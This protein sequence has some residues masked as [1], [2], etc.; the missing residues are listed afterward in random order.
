MASFIHSLTQWRPIRRTAREGFKY[1]GGAF[2]TTVCAGQLAAVGD[3]WS[4]LACYFGCLCILRH[5][6]FGHW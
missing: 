3:Y 4:A 5:Q 6:V 2:L 1:L